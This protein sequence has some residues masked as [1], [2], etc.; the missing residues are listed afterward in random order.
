MSELEKIRMD[1]SIKGVTKPKYEI[2]NRETDE[3]LYT[4][5]AEYVIPSVI[6][7]LKENKD[8]TVCVYL[9]IERAWV[10][11]TTGKIRTD[12]IK[13]LENIKND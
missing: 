6:E 12:T 2:R 1:L 3:L 13:D 7:H 8:D 11:G 9:L 5:H 4:A 10:C